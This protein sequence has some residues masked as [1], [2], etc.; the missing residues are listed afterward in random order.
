M[1][2]GRPFGNKLQSYTLTWFRTILIIAVLMPAGCM[3]SL[4]KTASFKT[5]F[6]QYRDSENIMAIS[7]PPG[8]VGLFL[9]DSDPG[10]AELKKLMQELSSFR[11]LFLEE[12]TMND[13]LAEE[14]RETVN[15]FTSRNG[16]QDLL[17]IQTEDEDIFIRIQEKNGVVKEAIL[18]MSAD[19]NFY[20]ID[21]RG[22]ISIDHFMR[23]S[24]GGY[25]DEL[26]SLAK[27]DF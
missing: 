1:I 8:L 23:L 3:P 21:L 26:Y 22:D 19:D 12:G 4:E 2:P 18:M 13:D 5:I 9:S 17:R 7:F 14:L 6:D 25:L 27:I 24:E 16:F 20:V 10:Q 11:M 15:G